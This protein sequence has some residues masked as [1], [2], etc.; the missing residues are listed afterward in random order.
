MA[1]RCVGRTLDRQQCLNKTSVG[2][3]C[4]QHSKTAKTAKTA[5]T[6]TAKC[7][8][9][10]KACKGDNDVWNIECSANKS[11]AINKSIREKASECGR[12]REENRVCR[13]KSGLPVD[14][15]HRNA[16]E[17]MR[18]KVQKCRRIMI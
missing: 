12:L 8:G 5:K 2:D 17:K 7:P 10:Q 18:G 3:R 4:Y 9:Y 15:G 1:K 16:I 11:Q 6:K 14:E 13:I